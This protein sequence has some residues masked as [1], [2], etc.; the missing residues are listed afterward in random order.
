MLNS[1]I[2]LYEFS[3]ILLNFLCRKDKDMAHTKNEENFKKKLGTHL[4]RIQKY[5]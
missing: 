3:E 1:E 5:V 2:I 4:Q